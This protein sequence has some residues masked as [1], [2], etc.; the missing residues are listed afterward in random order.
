M[1]YCTLPDLLQ[2]IPVQTLIQL[3]NDEVAADAPDMDVVDAAVVQAEELVDAH[4][5]GRYTLPLPSVP[6]VIKSVAVAL[7]RHWLYARR[8]EGN[9]LPDAV[10]ASYR[11][12]IKTLEAV[13]DAKL[14]LGDQVTTAQTPEPGAVRVRA[15]ARMFGASTLARF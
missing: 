6:T 12:A 4:L 5:R 3:S 11:D 7:V 13:R 9:D 15:N 2:A 8:P 14:T 10:R 1:R